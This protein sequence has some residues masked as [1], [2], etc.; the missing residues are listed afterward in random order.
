MK[1]LIDVLSGRDWT[2]DKGWQQQNCA[3]SHGRRRRASQG[4]DRGPDP[5][6]EITHCITGTG[7]HRPRIILAR[8]VS[9]CSRAMNGRKSSSGPAFPEAGG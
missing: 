1:H 7:R 6:H 4:M 2:G 8:W 9:D 5:I 3:F